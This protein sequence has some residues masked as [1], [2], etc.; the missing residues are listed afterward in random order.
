MWTF[1]N[2]RDIF[3]A[4]PLW[5]GVWFLA[6]FVAV[7]NFWFCKD[8]KFVILTWIVSILFWFHFIS[9]WL[10]TAWVINFLDAF[11]NF[12]SL[13]YEKNI[14]WVIWLSILYLCIGYFTYDGYLSLIP[15]WAALFSTYLVF[16]VRG[17]KLNLWFMVIVVA[18][19]LYNY[20]WNSLWGFS[21]DVFLLFFGVF[22]IWN[23][24]RESI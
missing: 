8:Q 2:I 15:L 9:L 18:Y 23:Q 16:Y 6:F 19:M 11:K 13:K 3:Q 5:Q 14:Y 20:M 7:Y 22:G 21:T 12:I 10:M 4:N 24:L 17:I 1:L